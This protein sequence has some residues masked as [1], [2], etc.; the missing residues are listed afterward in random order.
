MNVLNKLYHYEK[1]NVY[2]D[3]LEQLGTKIDFVLDKT[4]ADLVIDET[5]VFHNGFNIVYATNKHSLFHIFD[6]DL[7]I[8]T[9]YDAF[10]K[11][12]AKKFNC[13]YVSP[14][15]LEASV[16]EATIWHILVRNLTIRTKT[17]IIIRIPDTNFSRGEYNA[18]IGLK[19]N[20]EIKGY[21]CKILTYP[22]WYLDTGFASINMLGDLKLT[23]EKIDQNE[24]KLLWILKPSK[25]YIHNYLVKFDWVFSGS[26]IY[27]DKLLFPHHSILY[28]ATDPD[29][30]K[31]IDHIEISMTHHD[32][33]FK[34]NGF[35]DPLDLDDISMGK[36]VVMDDVKDVKRILQGLIVMN[37]KLSDKEY[38]KR[39]ISTHDP[40]I[41]NKLIRKMKFTY[42]DRCNT[43]L[44]KINYF[45]NT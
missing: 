2:F 22:E 31:P 3:G 16:I 23:V 25:Q 6:A 19:K 38:M 8:S 21:S 34:A 12:F 40:I 15:S 13:V 32:D 26:H 4:I 11:G 7:I 36:I 20:L 41:L 27:N 10:K 35:I 30:N 37:D 39:K 18:G 1:I 17:K 42:D 9:D 43:F 33:E 44:E 45:A 5:A 24:K 28:P 29:I 14:E